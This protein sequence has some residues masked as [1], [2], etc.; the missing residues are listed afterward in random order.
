MGK[1]TVVLVGATGRFGAQVARAL[2][3]RPDV[4]LRLLARDPANEKL[5]PLRI[6]GANVIGAAL[7]SPASLDAALAGADVVVSTLDGGPDVMIA[8]QTELLRAAERCAVRRFIPSDYSLDY[9]AVG[10]GESSMLDL[11]R[12]FARML[13][14]SPIKRSHVMFGTFTEMLLSRRGR[15]FDFERCAAAHW[16]TG[17]EPV[18]LTSVDDA[19]RVV[20][21]VALDPC[22]PERVAFVGE[23]I[24]VREIGA[25]FEALTG[26]TLTLTS[27]GS[28]DELERWIAR[29]HALALCRHDIASAEVQRAR[30]NG[31]GRIG[32][33]DNARFPEITP[34]RTTE[35][36]RRYLA[37]REA[38]R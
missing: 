22:S 36:L 15:V 14:A 24:S 28:L 38:A 3:P 37:E 23:T 13:A 26:R 16:G 34:K 7:Q 4:T 10:G 2:L 11:R 8:G 1:Q 27:Y 30:L 12:Q 18:D 35:V 29:L 21:A 5:A 31:W 19:A 6:A 32:S 17:D 9:F 25:A 33:T 20:A